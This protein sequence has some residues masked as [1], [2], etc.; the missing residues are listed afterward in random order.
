MIS[1]PHGQQQN[2]K[3]FKSSIKS[4]LRKTYTMW[5]YF[6]FTFKF[7]VRQYDMIYA[8]ALCSQMWSAATMDN[9]NSENYHLKIFEWKFYFQAL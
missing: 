7:H 4:T 9:I 6:I 1:E 2:K 3:T 5:S 8:L